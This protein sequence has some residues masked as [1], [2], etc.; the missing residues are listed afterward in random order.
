MVP[1]ALPPIPARAA[2]S[3]LRH[4][5]AVLLLLGAFVSIGLWISEP[6]PPMVTPPAPSTDE[7]PQTHPQPQ[8]QTT[9]AK[10]VVVPLKNASAAADAAPRFKEK[11]PD[12]SDGINLSIE[13]KATEVKGDELARAKRKSASKEDVAKVEENEVDPAK[14]EAAASQPS[15]AKTSLALDKTAA[16][17]ST[18]AAPKENVPPPVA[19]ADVKA[20]EKEAKAKPVAAPASVAKIET[21][22]VV[23]PVQVKEPAPKAPEAKATKE[24]EKKDASAKDDKKKKAATKAE[25][26][27]AAAAQK[28]EEK[29]AAAAQKKQEKQAAATQK[30]QEKTEKDAKGKL[31]LKLEVKE[32]QPS[33]AD[34]TMA[35]ADAAAQAKDW[36]TARN[37]YDD[38][39][40]ADKGNKNALRG[41]IV[42]LEHE[43]PETAL[44]SLDALADRYPS[45][46][47]VFATR[48]RVL[49]RENDT[50]EALKAW[51]RAVKL[52][53][54]NNDYKLGLAVL[55]DKL[56][57]AD[58]ALALY[59]QLP[60][61]LPPQAQERL[62][63]LSH[64]AGE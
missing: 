55:Q 11:A 5:L 24:P 62:D 49:L 10:Q 51:Q 47:M 56:G 46:A 2:A 37:L 53:P 13:S 16:K 30:K 14:E 15:A 54:Q 3:R 12:D 44:D 35:K 48:A 38:V 63:F 31:A 22:P 26:K 17:K 41:K 29:K 32:P 27:K 57:H 50:I 59:K 18:A 64:K 34:E 7:Q 6:E 9:S 23:Q 28:A 25:E 42:A 40:K 58:E 36:K 20:P 60:K 52:E 43:D 33:P 45:T 8:A 19:Q 39:L 4:G 21:V 1:A 61:P